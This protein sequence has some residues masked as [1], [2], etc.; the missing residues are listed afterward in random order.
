MGEEP[1]DDLDRLL[2]VVDGDVHVHPEDEL[3]PRDVLHLVDESVVAILRGDPLALE[4]AERVR[5]GRADAR[6]SL[7]ARDPAHVAAERRQPAHDVARVVAHRR[8]DL[9]HRLHELG[10]D[11]RL[12]LVARHRLRASS[13]CAGRGRRS[14]HRGAGTP[15]RRRA[16]TGTC[17]E[18]VVEDAPGGLRAIAGDGGRE[19][20][21]SGHVPVEREV[22]EP[23]FPTLSKSTR[24]KCSPATA[25]RT[26][27]QE[28][29]R[30]RSRPSISDRRGRRALSCSRG[31]R[32]RRPRRARGRSRRSRRRSRGT[33]ACAR[34]AR[35][36]IPPA[37]V[38][39][40]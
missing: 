4:E 19:R 3:A 15:P 25:S 30:P 13:R 39:F 33:R 28:R 1:V 8:R 18:R 22:W 35:G 11:P 9:E 7:P 36:S 16:C 17:S 10:V 31:A 20:L 26:S 6:V 2:R 14:R 23:R 37:R 5:A 27:W 29:L 12:E 38:R 21:L 32:R 24:G 34:R 40:R